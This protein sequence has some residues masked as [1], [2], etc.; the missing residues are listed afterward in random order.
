VLSAATAK[1]KGATG[2]FDG[3]LD[4]MI[5]L[6]SNLIRTGQF[7]ADPPS[8]IL[9][10]AA[11]VFDTAATSMAGAFALVKLDPSGVVA[12]WLAIATAIIAAGVVAWLARYPDSV[13]APSKQVISGVMLA[14]SLL[15]FG[16]DIASLKK[17]AG[18]VPIFRIWRIIA[19]L[20][21][22]IAI[23]LS[24]VALVASLTES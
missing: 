7:N 23:L 18:K 11:T 24:T 12:L 4:G 14:M 21:S 6:V 17:A 2:S 3:P 15:S 1:G 8:S 9:E 10:R 20:L 19:M 22:L 16:C 13:S 5:R